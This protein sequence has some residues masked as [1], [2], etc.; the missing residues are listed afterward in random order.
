VVAY[1]TSLEDG[2][3]VAW[4]LPRGVLGGAG[5]FGVRGASGASGDVVLR[6]AAQGSLSSTRLGLASELDPE[7]PC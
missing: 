6:S 3:A 5:L 7:A 4:R 2:A 1:V